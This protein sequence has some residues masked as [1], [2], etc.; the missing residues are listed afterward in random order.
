MRS[1]VLGI[2]LGVVLSFTSLVHAQKPTIEVELDEVVDNRVTAG[3]WHGSLDLRVKLKGGAVL[4]KANAARVLVK[5]ARD[6]RGTVLSESS[7]PPDF[8]PRDYNSGTLNFSLATPAR[9]ASSVKVKGTVE[10]YAPARDPN[11]IVTVDKAL[12]TLDK[13]LSAKALKA[14][15]VTLTPLSRA[16]YAAAQKA[17]RLDDAKIAE[18]RAEGKKRGVSDAEIEQAIGLAKAFENLDG[19]L[20]EHAVIL[21]GTEADF[22]RVFRVEVLGADGKP[23][24]VPS[25]SVSTRG[26]S[27]VMTLQTSEAPP[28]NAALQIYLLTDKSR[29]SSPFELTVTLP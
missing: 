19:D 1:R 11:A 10:L 14:A 26:T 20:P 22:K 12:G 7:S 21:S 27:S 5:E 15:K 8:M 24:S 28:P 2:S 17:N 25:R 3:Q 29:V 23:M 13:P 6:D 4:E 16:G 18:I 9:A